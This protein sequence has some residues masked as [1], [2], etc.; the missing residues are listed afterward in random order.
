MSLKPYYTATRGSEKD[1]LRDIKPGDHLYVVN[2]HSDRGKSYSEWIVTNKRFLGALEVKSPAHGGTMTAQRL[3]RLERE[4][5]TQRPSHLP[6]RG[7]K[8]R[9]DA[10]TEDAQRAAK[11]VGDLHAMEAST[12]LSEHYR[13]LARR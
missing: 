5:L 4:V 8:D 10:Y 6:N 12:A 11:L 1:F 7:A 2:E 13:S 3:L 9:H